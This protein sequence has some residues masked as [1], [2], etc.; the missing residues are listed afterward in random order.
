[1]LASILSRRGLTYPQAGEGFSPTERFPEYRFEA[2]S[3][4]GN[5]VYPAV[6]E[7]LAQAGLDRERFGTPEWNPLGRYV[8]SGSQVFVLCNFVYHQRPQD[9]REDF[10][11]KCTHGSVLRALIDYVL[12]AVGPKGRVLFGNSPLQSCSWGEVQEQSG[13]AEMTRFYEAAG[14]AVEPRDLRLYVAERSQLGNVVSVERRDESD[15]VEIDLG[16]DSLLAE[17]DPGTPRYRV[18]DYNPDRIDAFHAGGA[19]RYIVHRHVLESDVVISLPKL[20]THEKVGITCGL[21]GFVGTVGHK[22]CLA[23]HRF[24]EP[25]RGGDEYPDRHA[26]LRPISAMHDW[27]NRRDEKASLQGTMQIL[28]RTTRRIA[29]RLGLIMGGAWHGNDTAWRMTLD[30]ARIVHLADG[31]GKLHATARRRHLMLLDGI[32]AG[33]GNGPLAPTPVGAGSLLF[34]DNVAVGD[35]IAARMMGFDPDGLELIRQAFLR[36]EL[37]LDEGA[38]P[39]S[40]VVN[41]VE[42]REEQVEAVLGRPFHPPVGWR[43]TLGNR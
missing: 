35:R 9:S 16:R 10:F 18:S 3:K 22:D 17:L 2:L 26:I 41:G 32:V 29:R 4:T 7:L 21:K 11:A 25:N 27:L 1:M 37:G 13:A 20:K 12:L 33:E 19:H 30:L 40:P 43:G 31:D 36:P 39:F 28:E 38:A 15:G 42:M 23:H 14:E 6:R 34:A 8:K 24:G 5:E